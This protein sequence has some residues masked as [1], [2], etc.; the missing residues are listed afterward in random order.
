M[1]NLTLLGKVIIEGKIYAKT[2]LHI[3]GS[4]VGL[5]VGGVDLSV[6]TDPEGKPYIPGSSLKG[7]MRSLLEKKEGLATGENRVWVKED[8]V[9]IHLCNEK[10]CSVCNIFG[11]PA[12]KQKRVSNDEEFLITETTPTR[13]IVRD[14]T[15]DKN[16]I[17]EEMKKNIDLEWTEVKF[18]N[19]IDRI[20]SSAT[21]RQIERVPAGAEFN[22]EIVYNILEEKDKDRLKKVFE[23][24]K[25]L[26]DDYLG[27]HGSRGYGQIEFKD[28]KVY[29]N[30]KQDYENGKTKQTMINNNL[31]KSASLIENFDQIKEGLNK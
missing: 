26:E 8:E 1:A 14:A 19:A 3:G 18:E 11:R 23:A 15:L 17:K 22:F 6:I 28:I 5:K 24:M 30:K 29:Y 20:K 7:K 4:Q 12:G 16:S 27:G 21:P 13:L 31:N 25:L 10:D 2:G 9:G